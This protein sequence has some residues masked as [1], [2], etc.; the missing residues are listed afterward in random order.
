MTVI[1]RTNIV[2][3][4]NI[5]RHAT[6]RSANISGAQKQTQHTPKTLRENFWILLIKVMIVLV[7]G[8]LGGEVLEGGIL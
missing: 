7:K 6:L 3:L 5:S 4:S 1:V 8:W 2:T